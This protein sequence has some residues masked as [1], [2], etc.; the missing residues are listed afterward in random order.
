[1]RNILSERLFQYEKENKNVTPRFNEYPDRKG[2]RGNQFL[3]EPSI[4]NVSITI[5]GDGAAK[6]A[7][8]PIKQVVEEEI[9]PDF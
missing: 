4:T 8:R 6:R 3:E 7:R 9:H 2:T 5:L 1:V